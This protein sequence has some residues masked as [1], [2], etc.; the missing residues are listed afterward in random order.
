MKIYSIFL[1]F[2]LTTLVKVY[3]QTLAVKPLFRISARF[4]GALD[5]DPA[6]IYFDQKNSAE[7]HKDF[8]ALKLMNTDQS[9]PSLYIFSA[10]AKRLS[11]MGLPVQGITDMSVPLG[12]KTSRAGVI[13]LNVQALQS[14]PYSYIYL[15]DLVKKSVQEIHQNT[16]LSIQ[17]GSGQTENRFILLF[18]NKQYEGI[19]APSVWKAYSS[20]GKVYITLDSISGLSGQLSIISMSGQQIY[21]QELSNAGL[22]TLSPPVSPGIY[23]LSFL[24]STGNHTKKIILGP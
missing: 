19:S 11:I 6:T 23:I 7:F 10:D 1:F 20:G 21:R 22:H 17:L 5:D 14:L 18:R 8:D 2:F 4:K 13:S 3:G 16:Q 12:I 24:S 9:V 15:Q